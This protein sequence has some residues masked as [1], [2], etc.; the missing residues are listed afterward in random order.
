[1]IYVTDSKYGSIHIID[2]STN[3]IV[4]TIQL[5]SNEIQLGISVN[6]VTNK[7]YVSNMK[8]GTLSILDTEPFSAAIPEFSL[9]APMILV[10]SILTI[11][12]MTR[13]EIGNVKY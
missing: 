8:S 9:L 2:G 1:M 7:A 5:D 11:T 6:S 13:L 4:K 12:I 10:I 3:S